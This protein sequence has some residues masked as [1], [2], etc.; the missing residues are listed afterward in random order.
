[1]KKAY[2]IRHAKADGGDT[3]LP[4]KERPL[5]SKGRKEARTMADFLKNKIDHLDL[6]YTSPARRAYETASTFAFT[7]GKGE[8]VL[9]LHARLYQPE[10]QD[11]LEVIRETF[12][13]QQKILLC[14]HNPACTRLANLYA[15]EEIRNIPPGGI[16]EMTYDD[17]NWYDFGMGNTMMTGYWYPNMF[18]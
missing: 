15:D 5:S 17:Q 12:N 16:V 6:I 13:R 4:D 2:I 7:F 14:T 10:V 11:I 1:M 3:T 9:R 18:E 8:E